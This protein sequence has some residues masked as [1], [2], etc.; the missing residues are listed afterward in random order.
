[1]NTSSTQWSLFT[2]ILSKIDFAATTQFTAKYRL[3]MDIFKVIYTFNN[4]KSLISNGKTRCAA[5]FRLKYVD[6]RVVAVE[7]R[8]GL[9]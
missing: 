5:F 9:N 7:S 8:L 6:F 2:L 3:N 1:M 4:G